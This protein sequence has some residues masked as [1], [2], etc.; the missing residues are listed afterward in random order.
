MKC[1]LSD[2]SINNNLY[3]NGYIYGPN[4]MIID[5]S[6]HDNNTEIIIKELIAEGTELLLIQIL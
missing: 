3:I 5:P 6:G 4:N 1:I 2:I